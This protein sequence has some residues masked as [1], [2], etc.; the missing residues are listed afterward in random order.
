MIFLFIG[1]GGEEAIEGV[2]SRITGVTLPGGAEVKLAQQAPGEVRSGETSL[3]TLVPPKVEGPNASAPDVSGGL[4]IW[5]DLSGAIERDSRYLVLQNNLDEHSSIDADAKSMLIEELQVFNNT[6]IIFNKYLGS[7]ANCLQRLFDRDADDAQI[8]LILNKLGISLRNYI[9]LGAVDASKIDSKYHDNSVLDIA[10]R[11]KEFPAFVG[12]QAP[13]T[14]DN[15]GQ[16]SDWTSEIQTEDITG[17]L[18]NQAVPR[19][20]PYLWSAAAASFAF[21]HNYTA[22]ITLIDRWI[23]LNE[24]TD[25]EALR[26][27]FEIR[28]RSLLASFIE[29]WLSYQP[30]AKTQSVLGYHEKNLRK[31]IELVELNAGKTKERLGLSLAP[32][33]NEEIDREE[34]CQEFS[35]RRW[36]RVPESLGQWNSNNRLSAARMELSLIATLIS[37]KWTWIDVVLASENYYSAHSFTAQRFADELIEMKLSCLRLVVQGSNDDPTGEDF[38]ALQ[39][40]HTLEAFARVTRANALRVAQSDEK[41]WRLEGVMCFREGWV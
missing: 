8:G 18:N 25:D 28:M 5:S 31:A 36:P 35:S 15:S 10:V 12:A 24:P 14:P 6:N 40:A 32:D 41:K 19:R 17:F 3:Y 20:W 7:L 26:R 30:L 4:T 29:E 21:A 13:L 37:L 11:F 23:W 34:N 1:L 16:C 22:A 33:F 2:A 39:R 27:I 9:D 38:V